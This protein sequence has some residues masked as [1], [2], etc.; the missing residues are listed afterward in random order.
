MRSESTRAALWA[1]CSGTLL[2]GLCGA[3]LRAD[4]VAESFD[5]WSLSGT[6]GERGWFYG[7]YN[8]TDDPNQAYAT[9]D[10][11]PFRNT[12]GPVS[13]DGNHWTGSQW[14]L[15]AAD[16]GPWT[17]LGREA[18]HPNGTNS[19]PQKEHWT[20]RRWVADRALPGAEITWHMR[21]TNTGCGNGV[22]GILFVNGAVAD[23]ARIAG[24]D[25]TGVTRTIS[26]SLAAGDVVDLALTPVGPDG[27]RQ[28]GC[29]GSANRLT[30]DDGVEDPDGDGVDSSTDNCPQAAN[31]GQQDRDGD[32][33]GDACDNCPDDANSDQRDRDR[34]GTGDACDDSPVEPEQY[35]VVINEVHFDPPEGGSLEFIE[36]HNTR[37]QALDIGGWAF[38]EG[39][40]HE[41][42]AGTTIP[43]SG[44]LVICRDSRALAAHFGVAEAALV[45]WFGAALENGGE[46][47]E[48]V[49]R[50]GAVVDSVAYD[51]DPPWPAG[52]A[53]QGASLQRIC[54]QHDSDS[55]ANW[56]AAAG[57]AP[58][59][60]AANV[61]AQCPPPPFPPPAVAINEINYHPPGFVSDLEEDHEYIELVNTTAQP[62]DLAGFC[63]T[64][65]VDF[66]FSGSRVLAPGEFL[67]VCKDRAAVEA[68][69]GVTNTAGDWTGQLS[70]DGERIT[71]VDAAGGLVDSVRYRDSGDWNIGPDEL[72]YTLEKI[73][74]TAISDD[75]ASWSDSGEFDREVPNEWQTQ[76]ASG[77][78]TSSRIYFYVLGPGEFLIDNVSLVDVANPGQNLVPAASSTFDSGIGSWTRNGNHS[79]SRWSRA[80]GGTIFDEPALHV[81]STGTGTGSAN[82]V[83]LNLSVTLD[84]SGNTVYRLSFSYLYLSG[85]TELVARLS[86]A[87]PSLG[88]FWQL[89]DA[90]GAV[91]SPGAPNLARRT[92]LPPFVT[93]IHRTP[94][95]PRSSDW[96]LLTCRVRGEVSEVTLIA[97]TPSGRREIAMLDDGAS[98]D[99]LLGDGVYGA[100][101][102]PQPHNTV[103]TF[104]IEA[105]GSGGTRIFPPRTDTEPV[106]AYYVNDSQPDSR[107]S[108]WDL[109]VPSS[110]AR[111]WIAS[112][113]RTYQR[114]HIA[115][116]GHVFYNVQMRQR[117]ASV[118]NATKRF[119]K[120]K[121]NKG[122]LWKGR[123][124]V[125]LQSMWPDK[126]LIRERMAWEAFGEMANPTLEHEYYRIHANGAY[127]ALYSI[128]EQP[129]ENWLDRV[130]L[131]ADGDLY[132][133]VASR[134]ERD[135][136]YEK[137]TNDES[138][139]TALRAFLNE[140]H[141]TN[142]A[143]GLVAFFQRT[144][145][146]DT[147]VD[148]QAAQVL[149]NNRDYPHKNHYL[150][151]DTATGRW[152]VTGWDLDLCYGKRWD[153]TYGGVYNDLMDNPGITPWYTT[154]VRGEGL[155]NHL[156]DRFFYQAGAYYRRAY[157]VRLWDAIHEKYSIEFY[158]AKIA[159]LRDLIFEEQAEDI[160]A[161]GR[162]AP[163]ANDPTA[164]AEFLP[165]LERV[166]QHIQIRR[167]YL[168]NYLRTTE[169]FTGHDRLMATEVMYNPLGDDDAE[170]VELWNN[171][172][173]SID[174]SSWTIEGLGETDAGGTRREFVFP[175][176]TVIAADEVVVV[177]K[178]PVIFEIV[179]GRGGRVFGPYPGNLDNAGEE[180][181]VKDDGPNYPAT[182]DIV[183]YED[184]EPWPVRP[185]GLG[186]SLELF[187]VH[188]DIDND[189]AVNW[190]TSLN[191]HGSP[192][193]I[194]RRGD[195]VALFVRGNCNS[196]QRVDISDAVSILLYLFVGARQPPCLD[197]CDVNGDERIEVSDAV[198]V[199]AYLFSAEG[200]LIPA[201]APGQCLP[202]REGFCSRTNCLAQ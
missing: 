162:T 53:G 197:G 148:Y 108:R 12:G 2:C 101:V 120:V 112:L 163:T 85:S 63:F 128:M 106:Y 99:G 150:Y 145:D 3:G 168:I 1:F 83:A 158:E 66:C 62:I 139:Y 44:F 111:S 39:I 56:T 183:R 179:H 102:P 51:D 115:A 46:E 194:H 119:L 118:Y 146:A 38:T 25:G 79:G 43:A 10:F 171:S 97:T 144:V 67:V 131:N 36:L 93:A 64:Q 82:S 107:I 50:S 31:P 135:G 54:P 73:L 11:V 20:I 182:V 165:N 169:A 180:L 72:G 109:I 33:V 188:E 35:D 68:R 189:A 149:I 30:I 42:A 190:R 198:A 17:E 88:I 29:D 122:H 28:D 40:R 49:D 55:P 159:R 157:L 202:A 121:F 80:A 9:G 65:G 114:L 133:A 16:S 116:G 92:R 147:I 74:P 132:K 70:N 110:N 170:F 75:P 192:W 130:G 177:A 91:A 181:R 140:M 77:V 105:T 87:S 15:L 138:D 160:A 164:P 137:K 13:P 126:S 184:S 7:Y 86:S 117:G 60:L 123:R 186:Y 174:V 47:I 41:F 161:W 153:G 136:R 152:I 200:Y 84:T 176:G 125:N 21:K 14:D 178:D 32:Q 201:P 124:L 173:R 175:A 58:T 127:Y 6:Q 95:E 196:D 199:L 103:V 18:T 24:S 94:A 191:L 134:E 129:D 187:G 59:P 104:Q 61:W 185:D 37:P 155:G 57:E 19:A 81:I 143:S 89:E 4:V 27:S 45:R 98:S 48:L 78:A 76:S 100:E 69:F 5:D 172:G 151:Q 96:T 193:F 71:L 154:R 8:Y 142:T 195:P 113:D 26:R 156:L 34:D 52:A 167:D 23:S 90:P 22:E 166:R 141:D